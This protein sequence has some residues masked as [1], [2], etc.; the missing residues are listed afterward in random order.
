MRAVDGIRRGS[1]V[2]VESAFRQA[3][4]LVIGDPKV[5]VAGAA[6]FNQ[7]ASVQENIAALRAAAQ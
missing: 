7:Q 4:W 2:V 5:V 1:S 6:V 3:E